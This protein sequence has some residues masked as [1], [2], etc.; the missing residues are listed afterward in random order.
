MKSLYVGL[1]VLA[2]VGSVN[3]ASTD[4]AEGTIDS[5]AHD[6]AELAIALNPVVSPPIRIPVEQKVVEIKM[7]SNPTVPAIEDIKK[8]RKREALPLT[9]RGGCSGAFINNQG[10]ILTAKHCVDG[11]DKFYVQTFDRRVYEATVIATSPVHDLALIHIDR[12]NTA[13]FELSDT[14]T[15]GEQIFTLG[16]PLGITDTLSTGIVAHI[17]GDEV[18]ID[19]SAL[20][21]NSGGPLFNKEEKL[22]GVVTAGLI[23]LFGTTHL[24]IAQS[25]D[26]VSFFIKENVRRK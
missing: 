1:V 5:I 11:Y 9:R 12:R 6:L 8:K 17:D 7:I 18:F 13:Y 14:L 20:P 22:V 2:T 26:A 23:V 15:R 4:T 16:S 24:N 21:G 3:A 10:D 25:L 19:C